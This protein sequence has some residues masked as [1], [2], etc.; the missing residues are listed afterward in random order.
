MADDLSAQGSG[1]RTRYNQCDSA[2][3]YHGGPCLRLALVIEYVILLACPSQ[4]RG[5]SQTQRR[6]NITEG[7]LLAPAEPEHLKGG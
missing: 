7:V 6:R 4:Y 2:G 3:R 1:L 5:I